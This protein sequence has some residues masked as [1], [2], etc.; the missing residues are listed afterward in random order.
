[1]NVNF[2]QFIVDPAGDEPE[3]WPTKRVSNG[4]T[5]TWGQV[6]ERTEERKG[7]IEALAPVP[8]GLLAIIRYETKQANKAS[9]PGPKTKVTFQDG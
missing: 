3:E 1:M 2:E 7:H 8:G 5:S 9:Q 6:I 4:D